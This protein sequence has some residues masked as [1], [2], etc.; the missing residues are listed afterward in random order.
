[1]ARREK[2]ISLQ[3]RDQELTFRIREMSA[4]KMER[5]L[6]EA[7]KLTA[8]AGL[9]LPRLGDPDVVKVFLLE[10]FLPAALGRIEYDKAWPLLEALLNCCS[11]LVENVAEP[12][13]SQ[14]VEAYIED[15]STLI[16]LRCEAMR[17]NAGFF[18]AKGP[19]FPGSDASGS[20]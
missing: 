4:V 1:M 12:C 9:D 7:L 13:S 16:T 14:S 6:A 19:S 2:I 8:E 5:W 11:R 17:V 10:S 20:N 15:V 3:D 18:S